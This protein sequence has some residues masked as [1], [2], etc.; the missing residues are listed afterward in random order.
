[1]PKMVF[2]IDDDE[3]LLTILEIALREAG[4]QVETASNGNEA[5][6]RLRGLQPDLIICDVMMPYVDGKQFWDAIHERLQYE[7]IPIILMTA[8][9]RKQWFAD[10]EA[11]GTVIVQKP[12][13]VEHLISLVDSYLAE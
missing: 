4:Y 5:L 1:M 8:L 11:E 2:V 10:L 6:A 12:F 3:S 9:S 7:G 13:R